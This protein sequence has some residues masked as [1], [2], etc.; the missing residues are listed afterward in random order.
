MA[1]SGVSLLAATLVLVWI[2]TRD[3]AATESPTELSHIHGM[4]VNPSDSR[5]YVATHE[6]LFVLD[7]DG[8]VG[9]V[10]DGRQD[11]M[12]FTVAGRDHFLASG[13]PAP[14]GAGPSS[15]GLIESTDAGVTWEPVSLS[16]E[17]DFHVLR[18]AHGSAY[19]I[20][21][22]SGQ[23]LVS[24]DLTTWEARN[25]EPLVDV[26]VNPMDPDSLLGTGPSG[27]LRSSD[28]GRTWE[29]VP[30][31][32]MVL[33]HWSNN[34]LLWGVGPNGEIYSNYDQG[35]TWEPAI[36]SVGASPT[37]FTAAGDK[38]FLAA[39]DGRILS[40]D[41]WGWNWQEAFRPV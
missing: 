30:A 34:G 21:A 36:A 4:G 39:D 26:V 22:L 8:S 32:P 37:A 29:P 9:L 16:G 7:D 23:L 17:A 41:D 31:E 33:L 2:V 6:G 12:G 28:G 5:L 24:E 11:T 25:T 3:G 14:G 1:I 18:Y 35:V 27:L 10:G 38:L 40:S 15:L 19:G 13:H 20:D